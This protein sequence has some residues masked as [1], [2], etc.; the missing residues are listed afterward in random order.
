[1]SAKVHIVDCTIRDGGYLFDKN[2]SPEFVEG[3]L[4]GLVDAGIDFAETGFLQS[5]VGGESIVYHNSK[6]V[7]KYLPRDHGR[8]TYLGFCDNSRYTPEELDC[9]DGSSFGWLRI[10]FAKHE[11]EGS[12]G[13]CKAAMEKGYKVQFN[14]MDTISY[15]ERERAELIEKV[16]AVRPAAFSIVDTFGAMYMT[17]LVSIFRQFDRLLDKSVMI[18]LHSHDNLGLSCALAER[19]V[20]LAGETGREVCVDGSLFGM[21]RGAGNAKTEL[22][23]DYLNKH[24]GTSYDI[25]ALL[26]TIDRFIIPATERIHWGY[27][28]P[29]FVCGTGHSHVDNVNHLIATHNCSI[30]DIY[31]VI[32]SLS[33]QQRTRYGTGYSKTDFSQLDE[34]YNDYATK[35]IQR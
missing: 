26:E 5:K 29:M 23:A 14:P 3:V 35:N 15:T 20:E 24:C 30:T 28:L 34:K 10:S 27:D 6:D 7:I 11:I 18:G 8:T 4:Q 16:N 31:D 17:D 21:G 1:M 9:C 2:S 19:M 32:G 25:K 13:F 33:P 12:L 22:L